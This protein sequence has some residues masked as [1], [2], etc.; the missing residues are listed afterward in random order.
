MK[1]GIAILFSVLFLVTICCTTLASG[2]YECPETG[3]CGRT[4]PVRPRAYSHTERVGYFCDR[5]EGCLRMVVTEYSYGGGCSY[6]HYDNTYE[7]EHAYAYHTLCG[8]PEEEIN[9][10]E[11]PLL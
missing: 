4:G 11:D 8:S 7:V 6:C 9:S 5:A 1:K 10:L 3:G 2:M